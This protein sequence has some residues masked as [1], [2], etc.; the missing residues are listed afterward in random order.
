MNIQTGKAAQ[1]EMLKGVKVATE[2]IRLTYGPRGMNAVVENENYPYHQVAN[3]AQTIIQAI[4]LEDPIQKR[5][6]GFLKELMDKQNKDS[7]DGRK[8]TCIIAEEILQAG[9]DSGLPGLE[10]KRGLDRLIPFIEKQID[11]QKTEIGVKEVSK[12]ATIAAESEEIGELIGEIYQKIGADGIIAPEPSGTYETTYSVIHGVRFGDT[13]Y[14]SPYMAHDAQALAGGYREV[15]AVYENPTI[16]VT[17]KKIAHLNDINPLLDKLNSLGKKD[18]VIF[19]DDMDSGVASIMVKAH[20]DKV[21]NILIIKAPVIWKDYIFEDFAKVTGSTIVED[22]TGVNYKNLEMKHLGTCAKITV[23][24]DETIIIPSVDFSDHIK[25]LKDIK[26]NDSLLRLSWLQTE[27]AILKLGANSE[28]E[29]SYIRLKTED[30]I[31]ASRLA[32]KDGVVEGGGMCL[33]EIAMFLPHDLEGSILRMALEAPLLQNLKNMEKEE[34]DWGEEVIDSAAVV[35]NAVRNAVALA[36][37]ILTCGVV[38][39]LPK[40]EPIITK[41][42]YEAI[43]NV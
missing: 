17:K 21:V 7:G 11:E 33:N 2:A 22:A 28:S 43:R 41:N 5:G 4:E 13:G 10:L 42:P 14:L 35:K 36:S 16:L 8:T 19:T 34:P 40:K 23:D 38:V 25:Q 9:Y 3:D 37:T 27:T 31:N 32:L 1:L 6:L 15:K 26:D 12:V 29:L 20:Q 24:R 18:L 39:T 30:A